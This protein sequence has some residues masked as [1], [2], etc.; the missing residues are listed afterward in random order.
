MY[1]KLKQ[2][3]RNMSLRRKIFSILLLALVPVALVSYFGS[4]WIS[5]SYAELLYRS[6]ARQLSYSAKD[7]SGQLEDIESTG[8]MIFSSSTVQNG[9]HTILYSDNSMERSDA[10]ISM[11]ALLLEHTQNARSNHVSFI[12]LYCGDFSVSGNSYAS[13]QISEEVRSAARDV[14]RSGDGAAVWHSVNNSEFGLFLVREVRRVEQFSFEALGEEIICVDIAGMVE[15]ATSFGEEYERAEY[16]ILS[17]DAL[18]YHTP[19]LTHEQSLQVRQG[20]EDAYQIVQM[21]GHSYFAVRGSIP[22]YGWDYL[23]LLPYDG[24]IGTINGMKAL[25]LAML[26][27]CTAAVVLL[28]L[29]LIASLD[30]HFRTLIQKM[31][32]MGD[33]TS[34]RP[35]IPY[36]YQGRTDEIGVL[37]QQ[38]DLMADKLQNLIQTNYVNEILKK[39]AQLKALENQINPHFLYNTLESVN[40]R[41]KALGAEDISVMVQSLAAL[42]RVTLSRSEAVFTLREEIELVKSYMTIQSYRFEDRLNFSV[43]VPEELLSVPVGK[44][45]VQPLV[46]NAIHYGLE[47]N[48]EECEITLTARRHGSCAEILVKN[49]GSVFEEGLLDKLRSGEV[50]PHGHGIGLLNIDKRLKLTF[51]EAYG[52][53]LYNEGEWA[54]AAVTIPV[55]EERSNE[56]C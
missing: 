38:F 27:V 52:L 24:I 48:T 30:R 31:T 49:T 42:L 7:I 2:A 51:G 5:N 18:V 56:G 40:W 35:V 19:E 39:E 47:E 11:R 36:D 33:D 28:A 17:G 46:E 16:L 1:Q 29:R 41:A 45:V 43:N 55:R 25:F 8:F 54:V 22:G 6:V 21:N 15:D 50:L 23:C 32:A 12:D 13:R 3:L 14:A 44:L 34:Q 20:M 10:N 53:T 4:V 9:M 26:A 37:H